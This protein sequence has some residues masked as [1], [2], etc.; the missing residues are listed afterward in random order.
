LARL[1]KEHNAKMKLGCDRA[2]SQGK[3]W[4]FGGW[5]DVKEC[6]HMHG[7]HKTHYCKSIACPR[8]NLIDL[9]EWLK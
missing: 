6:N 8:L 2:Q 1:V 9:P 3:E 7:R 4:T 5:P